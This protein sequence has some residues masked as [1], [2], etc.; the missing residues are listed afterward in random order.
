MRV[1]SAVLWLLAAA[2]FFMPWMNVSQIAVQYNAYR[3]IQLA[4]EY[5]IWLAQT[6]FA[7]PVLGLMMAALHLT[8]PRWARRLDWVVV[9]VMLAMLVYY[10]LEL[11]NLNRSFLSDIKTGVGVY[12]AFAALGL[13]VGIRLM[14]KQ[15]REV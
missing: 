7:Y 5:E 1:V 12:V 9:A 2:T 11:Q 4:M 15:K 3:V 6:V 13:I 10:L 14:K 8:L